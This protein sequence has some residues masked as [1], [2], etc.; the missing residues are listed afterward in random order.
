MDIKAQVIQEYLAGSTSCRKL[1]AKYGMS[2][3]SVNKWVMS[4]QR[5]HNLP[6]SDQQHKYAISRMNSSKKKLVDNQLQSD[7]ALLQK[8]A[9]LEK[10]LEWEK[11]RSEALNTMINIAEKDLNI[12][13]RK[14]SGAQQ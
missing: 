9:A 1:S 5:I 11:L 4:H 7:Q 8:I 6:L 12:K 2:R 3:D 14:K 10:Q 13:I